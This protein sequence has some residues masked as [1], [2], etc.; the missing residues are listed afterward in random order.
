MKRLRITRRPFLPATRSIIPQHFEDNHAKNLL[1][2]HSLFHPNRLYWFI[3][4][5]AFVLAP[6]LTISCQ[7]PPDPQPIRECFDQYKQAILNQKG[8][9]AVHRVDSSTLR[10]YAL[11]K[12]AAL[13]AKE[14]EVR[15]MTIVDKLNVLGFRH[16]IGIGQ[17]QRLSEQ[18]L[19]VFLVDQGWIGREGVADG[20]LGQISIS[21]NTAEGEFLSRGQKT[22]LKFSFVKEDG[23]WRLDLT[24]QLPMVSQGMK[25]AISKLGVTEDEFIAN[26]LEIISG[27]PVTKDIWEPLVKE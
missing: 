21:G 12:D 17:L 11:M 6:Y 10:Y 1:S 26:M 2:T 20:G 24:A 14:Q 16:R 3:L 18:E 4:S 25:A 27:K 19:F 5:I 22:P 7:S 9:E 8:E 15:N 23:M 13:N